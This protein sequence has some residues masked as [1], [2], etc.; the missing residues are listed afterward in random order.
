[1]NV[2]GFGGKTSQFEKVDVVQVRIHATHDGE[3]VVVTASVVPMICLPPSSSKVRFAKHR[4][5]HL[6]NLNL[7]DDPDDHTAD[8]EIAMLIG[9]DHYWS[10]ILD[11]IHRGQA[12]PVAL[13]SR[14]GLVLSGPL[15]RGDPDEVGLALL[16]QADPVAEVLRRFWDTDSIGIS[17]TEEDDVHDQLRDTI[18]FKSGR[19]EVGLPWKDK[20]PRMADNY[21]QAEKRNYGKILRY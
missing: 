13:L 8:N 14:C 1:M 6:V 19:Y 7:A 21:R 18:T 5:E 9:A 12:G 10:I 16:I 4:Y 17:S 15:E 11:E 3:D 20:V 2:K